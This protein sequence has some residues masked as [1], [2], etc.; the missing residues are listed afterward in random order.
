MNSKIE[1][2]LPANG[3]WKYFLKI[4]SIPHPSGHEA[5]LRDML[6]AE[7]QRHGL[8]CR[9]DKAGNL[10]IDRA[11]AVG[12]EALPCIILQ[13][14]LDMVPQVAPGVE[15]DF[16]HDAIQLQLEGSWLTTNGR[17]TLGADDGMGIALAMELMTDPTLEC[18]PLRAVFTVCEETGLGGAEDIARE[19][20]DAAYLI[21]LDSD[22]PFV[23]G[24]AGGARLLGSARLAAKIADVA[25]KTAVKFTLEGMHGG[26]SGMDIH[27]NVG[28]ATVTLGSFLT[29]LEGFELAAVNAGTLHNAI[30]RSGEVSG[31]LAN[32][33]L[34]KAKELI[35]NYNCRLNKEL[36]PEPNRRIE[37]AMK[38]LSAPPKLV[39]T[40]AAQRDLLRL[41]K[42]LPHGVL[43]KNPD[44]SSA[45][46]CNLG[47]ITGAA[48]ELWQITMLARSVYNAERD[49]VTCQAQKLMQQ[50]NFSAQ[51]DSAY[52]SW[53]PRWDSAFLRYACNIYQELSGK[54]AQTAVIHGGLE[55]G[56]FCGMNPALQM[57]SFAPETQAV[58]S[59]QERLNIEDCQEK[60]RLLRA[61]VSRISEV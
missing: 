60:R 17:T 54:Q 5:E 29:E 40:D 41:W 61:L 1:S 46:S 23:I 35:G 42:L 28:S 19:F 15:F 27:L 26:H 11:A 21:N 39:L 6:Q 2:M 59:P 12:F 8:R 44:N 34:E 53:E 48:G 25:G 57:I 13:A 47:V 52:S 33:R 9:V 30:A 31:L 49:K 3:F 7:A 38:T 43:A 50:F 14:H 18:G 37:L 45:T 32:D 16:L 51:I 24:C 56:I 22:E 55:P 10:A 36:R 58:H 20:L 4:C